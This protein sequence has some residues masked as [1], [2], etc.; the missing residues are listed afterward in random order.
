MSYEHF[1]AVDLVYMFFTQRKTD[2]SPN[3]TSYWRIPFQVVAKVSEVLY[4]VNYG[5]N[6]KEQVVHCD[7]MTACK[8]QVLRGDGTEQCPSDSINPL[9]DLEEQD[10][11][12]GSSYK[13]VE[14]TE[15]LIAVG[16]PKRERRT[17]TWLQD[18]IQ[19]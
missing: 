10:D 15:E 13:N 4:K 2:C 19:D 12:F 8:A 3:L 1:T 11:D 17:Q 6:G 14:V 7:R 5:R 18:Y 9:V 16:R